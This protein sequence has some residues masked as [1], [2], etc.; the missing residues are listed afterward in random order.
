[1]PDGG[2]LYITSFE[3]DDPATMVPRLIEADLSQ[4]EFGQWLFQQ[5]QEIYGLDTSQAP[6]PLPQQALDSGPLGADS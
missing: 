4:G 2:I 5:M 3:G 1:M 6:P